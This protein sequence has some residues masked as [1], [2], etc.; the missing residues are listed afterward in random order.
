MSRLR[1][2]PQAGRAVGRCGDERSWSRPKLT[3][4]M[5]AVGHMK[6]AK[7]LEQQSYAGGEL[8]KPTAGS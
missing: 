3:R 2:A 7:G 8:V 4:A 6:A 1:R 5:V